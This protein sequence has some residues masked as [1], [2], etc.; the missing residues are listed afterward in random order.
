LKPLKIFGYT[1][2][3]TKKFFVDNNITHWGAIYATEAHAYHIK[4]PYGNKII[5]MQRGMTPL[6]KKE[7]FIVLRKELD[8]MNKKK[9]SYKKA[10]RLATER[11]W[12]LEQK[13]AIK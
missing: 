12:K 7:T 9:M 1:I 13:G 3:Y 11:E 8:L 6:Q 10:H 4:F 2:K 5:L